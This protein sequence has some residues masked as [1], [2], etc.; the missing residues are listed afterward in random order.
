MIEKLIAYFDVD[1]KHPTKLLSETDVAYIAGILD[2]EGS[3]YISRDSRNGSFYGCVQ[4]GMTDNIVVPWLTKVLNYKYN[5]VNRNPDNHKDCNVF[6]IQ[7]KQAV[8][9][10]I[11]CLPYLKLKNNQAMIILE[12]VF[13][14]SYYHNKEGISNWEQ[15]NNLYE[16]MR[17]LNKKGNQNAEQ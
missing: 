9:L 15:Q 16:K 8:A 13:L 17:L 4:L 12:L 5:K 1:E 2:G 10:L 14:Q 6:R 3:I 7:G 11:R